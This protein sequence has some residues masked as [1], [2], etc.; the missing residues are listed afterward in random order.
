M[1]HLPFPTVVL[2]KTNGLCS[3][4]AIISTGYHVSVHIDDTIFRT[5]HRILGLSS[6]QDC[7]SE[8]QGLLRKALKKAS[9]EPT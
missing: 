1:V 4:L 5:C 3:A 9:G 2:S 6:E 8:N 7:F